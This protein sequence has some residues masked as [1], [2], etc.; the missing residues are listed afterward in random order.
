M[1]RTTKH[2]HCAHGGLAAQMLRQGSPHALVAASTLAAMAEPATAPRPPPLKRPREEPPEAPPLQG[3]PAQPWDSQPR[4][5]SAWAR[6]RLAGLSAVGPQR[7][8]ICSLTAVL[9]HFDM[10]KTQLHTGLMTRPQEM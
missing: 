1:R 9:P 8:R 6:A 3:A 7:V 4:E 10:H 2:V 5:P